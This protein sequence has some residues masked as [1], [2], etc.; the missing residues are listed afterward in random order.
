MARHTTV[1]FPTINSLKFKQ[2]Q[3][4]NI[5][6][7]NADCFLS[8]HNEITPNGCQWFRLTLW[9]CLALRLISILRWVKA[10]KNNTQQLL[11]L[12]RAQYLNNDEPSQNLTGFGIITVNICRTV[13]P[14]TVGTVFQFVMQKS[15]CLATM[16]NSYANDHVSREGDLETQ[17]FG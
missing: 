7:V 11:V 9:L 16:V 10:H 15:S 1:W 12:Q 3:H 8:K 6:W 5:I 2:T 13:L 4:S 17:V 14:C